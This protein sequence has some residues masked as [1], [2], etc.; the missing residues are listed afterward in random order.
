[1]TTALDLIKRSLRMLGVYSIGEDPSADESQDALTALNATLGTLSNTPLVYAKT[2]DSIAITA[3]QSSVTVGPSGATVTTRPVM[4]SG[5]SY[6]LVDTT[7][8]PLSIFTQHQYD[9]IPWKAQAGIP[10]GLWCQMDMPDITVTLWPVP[11]QAMTLKLWSTKLLASFPALTTVVSLPPGYEDG[12]AYLLAE[13][14][15]PEYEVEVPAAVL[16]GVQRARNTLT[17]FEPPMLTL[18]AELSSPR[19]NILYGVS[20]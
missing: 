8:W 9:G 13:A 3:N 4:V 7:S 6:V 17:T 5:D 16:R 1:M 19:F 10:E 14:L 20:R 12:L 11:S 2:L 15:A 18:P